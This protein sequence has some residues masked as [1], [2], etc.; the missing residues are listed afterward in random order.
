VATSRPKHVATTNLYLNIIL[1]L[2]LTDCY[3][4]KLF[5]YKTT[6]KVAV[7]SC[8][9]KYRISRSK[10]E[11]EMCTVPCE[12]DVNTEPYGTPII[13]YLRGSLCT[14]VGLVK[15]LDESECGWG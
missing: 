14:R 5:L 11:C 6:S 2:C 7:N 10:S 9:L 3:V 15:D 4:D 13:L 1:E 12:I 8:I